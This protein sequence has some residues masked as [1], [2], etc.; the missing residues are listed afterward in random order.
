MKRGFNKHDGSNEF[1]MGA[2]FLGVVCFSLYIGFVKAEAYLLILLEWVVY[3]FIKIVTPG[4]L[5]YN[6]FANQ[7]PLCINIEEE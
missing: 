6:I 5:Y 4:H 2:V 3:N 7:E 1:F